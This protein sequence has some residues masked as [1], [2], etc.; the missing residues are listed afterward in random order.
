MD[1]NKYTIK[2]NSQYGFRQIMPTPT[3]EEISKFYA[4]EFYSAYSNFN[5]SDLEV[6]VK[7]REWLNDRRDEIADTIKSL[8]KKDLNG[9]SILDIGCGWGEH[10]LYFKKF[11]MQ[12][13]GFDPAPDAV[14]YAQ[15]KDLNV[16]LAGMEKMDVFEGK[17]FDIVTLFNVLEHLADPVNILKEINEKVLNKK[18]LLIIDVPNEFNPFQECANEI[19]NLSEWWVAPP[20]HL[21]YFNCDSLKALLKGTGYEIKLCESSFPLEM[22]MLFGDKYVGNSE[23]GKICHQKR[24]A[25]ETNLRKTGRTAVLRKFYESLAEL[26]LGRQIISFSQKN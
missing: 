19:Y 1:K 3:A 22:F 7:D 20:G 25:F 17:K 11:G 24:I 12:C 4:D 15:K 9:L 8:T 2:V 16:K 21:N 5:D 26:N 6:Q 23:T 13:Y 10:L 14:A 18:G